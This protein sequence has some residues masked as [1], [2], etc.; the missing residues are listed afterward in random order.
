MDRGDVR[1]LSAARH[2]T[3][4]QWRQTRLQSHQH[5]Q[6]PRQ[7]AISVAERMDQDQFRMHFGQCLGDRRIRRIAAR[8]L[9]PKRIALEA[10]HEAGN[11]GRRCELEA[12][13][14]NIDVRYSP[15]QA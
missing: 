12:A 3:E 8:C 14:S 6:Q 4:I 11:Q 10:G 15:A 5:R 13:L 1:R 9:P 2:W 7:S